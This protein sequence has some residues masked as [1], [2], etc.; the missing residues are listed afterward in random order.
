MKI[1]NLYDMI[2]SKLNCYFADIFKLFVRLFVAE[3]FLRSGLLKLNSW[4]STLYLF[5]SEYQVPLISWQ[6]A[7]YLGTA[8]ELILPVLLLLGLASRLSALALFIFNIIAVVSY[9]AIWA[10]GFYDHKLWGIMLLVTV[11]FGAGKIAIDE[12]ICKKIAS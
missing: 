7:A 1:F 4:D 3:A 10:G 2:F 9:P 12:L 11:F 6:L 5:E 8:F